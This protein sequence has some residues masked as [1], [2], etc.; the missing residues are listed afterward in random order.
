MKLAEIFEKYKSEEF[1]KDLFLVTNWINLYI[2]K[3]TITVGEDD[4]PKIGELYSH[5]TFLKYTEKLNE[6]REKYA[7]KWKKEKD[8]LAKSFAEDIA[9]AIKEAEPYIRNVTNIYQQ[10]RDNGIAELD[11][12]KD[13][14]V[15][16]KEWAAK[17]L[18]KL[19]DP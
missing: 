17:L 7:Q 19:Y 11:K 16:E 2:G 13:K 18:D 14:L 6:L 8:N 12:Q 9:I 10:V 3:P 5:E 15:G 1:T 4:K